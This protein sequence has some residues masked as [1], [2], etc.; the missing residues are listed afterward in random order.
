MLTLHHVGS[1]H[2]SNSVPDKHS[3]SKLLKDYGLLQIPPL[4]SDIL[5]SHSIALAPKNSPPC[6]N[7]KFLSP[8]LPETEVQ[9]SIG[10]QVAFLPARNRAC[11]IEKSCDSMGR[12]TK[13]QRQEYYSQ[14]T[15]ILPFDSEVNIERLDS[16]ESSSSDSKSST[17]DQV[18]SV[19]KVHARRHQLCFEWRPI[20][21]LTVPL[22]IHIS[23]ASMSALILEC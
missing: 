1:Q 15:H 2:Y 6:P 8:V 3:V 5:L 19:R 22:S 21:S 23:S 10:W 7:I 11:S 13:P 9:G 14:E 20:S 17:D 16:L 18:R 12:A 4:P